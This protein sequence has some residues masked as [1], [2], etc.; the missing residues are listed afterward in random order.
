M[1]MTIYS[2]LV[3]KSNTFLDVFFKKVFIQPYDR[4]QI[5][6]NYYHICLCIRQGFNP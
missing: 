4:I 6:V 1:I 5:Y 2:A 3:N